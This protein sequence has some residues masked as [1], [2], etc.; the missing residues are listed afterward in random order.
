[1]KEPDFINNV[2]KILGLVPKPKFTDQERREFISRLYKVGDERESLVFFT[3]HR[4]AFAGALATIL[5][6]F[7]I[8]QSFLSP[9]YPVLNGIKGTVKVYR[10]GKNEWIL[11]KKGRIRLNKNDLVKTFKDGQADL[12]VAGLYQMRL[13]KDSEIGLSEIPRKFMRSNIKYELAKGKV[14]TYYEKKPG[15]R[16]FI[17]ETPEADVT[18]VGTEFMVNTMPNAGKTWVGV[19]DGTV[20]VMGRQIVDP[21]ALKDA[22]VFVESG[23]KTVVRAGNSPTRPQRLIEDEL[24]ELEELFRIGTKPQVA[25]LISTGKTRVRELLTFTLLY[26]SAEKPGILP[27]KI[28]E[29]ER[30]FREI[31]KNRQKEKYLE[32]IKEF[33]KIVNQY[34]NPKYD[35]Q[36]LLFIG[37]Y[38]EYAGKHQKAIDVFQRII[39]DYPQ[40]N[41]ASIAQCAIGIIY[42]EKLGNKEEARKAYRKVISDYPNS[43]ETE[44]ATAGLNRIPG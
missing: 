16:Q 37:A 10:A 21:K 31:V 35:V 20:R 24:L 30:N 41:L 13:K 29:I 11:A 38:Y 5:A 33:E 34:P 4:V 40:S 39:D 36:F 44:E 2:K 42:E 22:T 19:L 3:P 18:V 8:Y 1:M 25:L 23:N 14:F 17:I 6:F 32:N 15:K 9:L 26:I 7:L 27:K 28:V 43:P 12:T